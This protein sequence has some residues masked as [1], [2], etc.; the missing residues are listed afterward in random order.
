MFLIKRKEVLS[1]TIIRMVIEAPLIAKKAKAGQFVIL[2]TDEKGERIPFTIA[3][4]DENEGTVEIIF[5]V[6]GASTLVLSKKEEG[7]YLSTFV[8]PLGN[9]TELDGY[10]NVAV[11][12]GGAGA[13]IALP[14]AIELHK[15]RVKVT[16]I[17]GFRNKDLVILE[18][19]FKEC[20]DVFIGV[21]DDGSWNEK[22]FVTD[23]LKRQIEEGAGFDLVIAIGPVLMMKAVAELTRNYHIKT[24]CSLNPLMIDGTGMCG[25]C[26]VSVG[27]KMKFACI[28]GPDFDAHEVDFDSLNLRNTTYRLWERHKY[29]ETCNLF[30]KEVN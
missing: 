21:S 3:N 25:C 15:R 9:A 24:I 29:G 13:A 4:Y 17:I 22:G 27:G 30:K 1:P 19:D 26:R 20:S 18:K 6:V 28:D 11:I 12:G 14:E 16:S 23:A 10:K 7:D 2:R 8:G 5:Q